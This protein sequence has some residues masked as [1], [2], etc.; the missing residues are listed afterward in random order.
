MRMRRSNESNPIQTTQCGD[1]TLPNKNDH[2][3]QSIKAPFT[4][5]QRGS[6]CRLPAAGVGQPTEIYSL[7]ISP[8]SPN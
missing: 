7:I 8:N 2:R 4:L 6:G 3:I 5:G 1:A